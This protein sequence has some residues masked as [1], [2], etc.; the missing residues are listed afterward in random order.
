MKVRLNGVRKIPVSGEYI[1]LDGLLKY[2]FVAST[3]GEA[4]HLI[5]S[6]MVF[7]GGEPCIERGRKVK[8]GDVVRCGGDTLIVVHANE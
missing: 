8:P 2:S 6:G 7:M 5:R 4:K 1:R 3:G